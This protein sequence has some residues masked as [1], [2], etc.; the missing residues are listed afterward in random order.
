MTSTPAVT[1]SY[2]QVQSRRMAAMTLDID[3]TPATNFTLADA[4]V[5]TDKLFA[6]Y[7]T[8]KNGIIDQDELAAAL[9][10]GRPLIRTPGN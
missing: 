3:P 7:D 9:R 8:D 1:A 10:R 5:A 4:K 2:Q 6:A